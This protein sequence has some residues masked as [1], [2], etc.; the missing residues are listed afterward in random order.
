M[1]PILPIVTTDLIDLQHRKDDLILN[2]G[3]MLQ[4]IPHAAAVLFPNSEW[5]RTRD[6]PAL[7]KY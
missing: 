1:L 5:R 7:K 3:K 6:D 2:A 4:Y